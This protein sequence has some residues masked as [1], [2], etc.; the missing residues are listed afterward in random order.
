VA[1]RRLVFGELG[2]LVYDWNGTPD[3][4]DDDVLLWARGIHTEATLVEDICAVLA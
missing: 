1:W 4:F 3:N 2:R